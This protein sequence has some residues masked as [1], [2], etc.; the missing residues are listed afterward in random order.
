M[1]QPSSVDVHGM[2][3]AQGNFQNAIE[4]VNG[5]YNMMSGLQGQLQSAWFGETS[6]A[7]SNAITKWLEDCKVVNAQLQHILD[8][9]S[10]STNV[11]ANTNESAQHVAAKLASGLSGF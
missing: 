11:Y 3:L 5:A 8:T 9:L 1:T 4:Q 2:V 10:A 6:T 7:F